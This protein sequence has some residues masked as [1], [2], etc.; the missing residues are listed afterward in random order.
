MMM[1]KN[2]KYSVFFL[3]LATVEH[4]IPGRAVY[5]A[6]SMNTE[7]LLSEYV[8]SA[9]MKAK[10]IHSTIEIIENTNP[11]IAK[12]RLLFIRYCFLPDF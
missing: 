11:V 10:I 7:A 3:S 6:S 9:T 5:S 2:E 12:V 4:M 8:D 1:P